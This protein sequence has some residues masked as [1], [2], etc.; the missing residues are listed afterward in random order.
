[1]ELKSGTLAHHLNVLE[2]N[3][4][5]KSV[6]DGRYRRFFLYEQ[7]QPLKF[8][9][10]KVQERIMALIRDH[11]GITISD[12]SSEVGSNRMVVNYHA[13]ILQEA[14]LISL[15][16]EGRSNHCY[17]SSSQIRH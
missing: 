17:P 12:I 13:K 2:D 8:R 15:E 7:K 14:G 4:F 1:M 16:R 3:E 10:S 6:Q 5:I 9:L 11:P